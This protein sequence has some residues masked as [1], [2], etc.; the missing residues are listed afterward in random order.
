[1]VEN[2]TNPHWSPFLQL[3]SST[4]PW[5]L[6]ATFSSSSVWSPWPRLAPARPIRWT[7][8]WSQ[9]TWCC[10]LCWH[11]SPNA[12]S[13]PHWSHLHFSSHFNLS[14]ISSISICWIFFL[15]LNLFRHWV[16]FHAIFTQDR[17]ASWKPWL[18]CRRWW[19]SP[20]RLRLWEGSKTTSCP[21]ICP[22]CMRSGP[23]KPGKSRR[24][25]KPCIHQHSDCKF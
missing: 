15:N 25:S 20:L 8:V 9:A 17:L 5:T 6:G 3:R 12:S 21:S 2:I 14:R 23:T 22:E 24:K 7:I 4:L 11:Q 16:C 10:L 19:R 1:M 18:L 13:T